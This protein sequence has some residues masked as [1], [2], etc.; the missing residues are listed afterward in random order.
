MTP[1][2]GWA[3]SCASAALSMSLSPRVAMTMTVRPLS[4]AFSWT[5]SRPIAVHG[6]VDIS[7]QMKPIETAVADA[8][9]PP[10]R[11]G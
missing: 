3:V 11:T 1:T 7:S 9:T 10:R 4:H 8:A 6:S 5:P 2:S